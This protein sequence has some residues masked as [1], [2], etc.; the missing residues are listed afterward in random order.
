MPSKILALSLWAGLA[1]L[2]CFLGITASLMPWFVSV[3]VGLLPL[4]IY[5]CWNRVAVG[6]VIYFVAVLV[7][8]DWKISDVLTVG[9]VGMYSVKIFLEKSVSS[10][11]ISIDMLDKLT[12]YLLIF[13]LISTMVAKLY[14]QNSAPF[15]YRDGR[16]FLYWAWLPLLSQM[17]TILGMSDKDVI[18]I[19]LALAGIVSSL[20]LLQYLTGVQIVASGKVADLEVTGGLNSGITRVQIPGLIFVTLS[21]VTTFILALYRRLSILIAIPAAALF[22]VALY[23]NFGRAVWIWTSLAIFLALFMMPY[24]KIRIALPAMAVT[25]LLFVGGAYFFKRDALEAAVDRLT[26]VQQEGGRATSYGWRKLENEDALK[27]ITHSPFLGVGLGGEY[28]RWIAEIRIFEDHTRFVHN[29]YYFFAIKIGLP[30]LGFIV[31]ILVCVWLR[32]I[33][34]AKSENDS[35][36]KNFATAVVATLP[37][38]FALN[39]TQPELASFQGPLYIALISAA[40]KQHESARQR[41]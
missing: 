9:F 29:V 7:S 6:F 19:I 34:L 25:A 24:S 5:I 4:I 20:A 31:T 14:F 38:F 37:A 39:I 35:L 3:V 1:L 15:M 23:V 10:E 22:I 17:R 36:Q 21:L 33:K 27:T 13:F 41:G 18:A 40:I 8:P 26:S 30:G 32:A 11:K 28:R 2:A 12:I 16:V